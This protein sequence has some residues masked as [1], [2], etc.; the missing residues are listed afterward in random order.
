MTELTVFKC[1]FCGKDFETEN[2]CKNHEK[3]HI[4]ID[5]INN[6]IYNT[7][8]YPVII[9]VLMENGKVFNYRREI[10]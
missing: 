10:C 2:E 5:K 6:I 3:K 8:K 7:E 9:E 1:D 4:K